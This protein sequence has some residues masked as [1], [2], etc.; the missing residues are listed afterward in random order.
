MWI[1]S[2]LHTGISQRGERCLVASR[3]PSPTCPSHSVNKMRGEN[4]ICS[5]SD[6]VDIKDYRVGRY[7][8][9]IGGMMVTSMAV[10]LATPLIVI[11]SKSRM[12]A[13]TSS[14]P[15]SWRGCSSR[16]RRQI[17]CQ[18]L[19]SLSF[20]PMFSVLVF[21][22]KFSFLVFTS[23]NKNNPKKMLFQDSP[24]L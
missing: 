14:P 6:M 23:K 8:M 18:F 7:A 3:R 20:L 5:V 1:Y 9:W 19:F 10:L 15:P 17:E 4:K 11:I 16:I 24:H 13:S 21:S 22:L 12:S 2:V